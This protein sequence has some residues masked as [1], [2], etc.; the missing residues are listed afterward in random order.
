MG[1]R[2]M[3]VHSTGSFQDHR[4]LSL[5]QRKHQ[6]LKPHRHRVRCLTGR[7]PWA[8]SRL[9]R[10]VDQQVLEIEIHVWGASLRTAHL[11]KR[12]VAPTEL[13]DVFCKAVLGFLSVLLEVFLGPRHRRGRDCRR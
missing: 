3:Q 8:R 7:D 2:H 12:L 13:I 5:L 11:E 6:R 1:S 4:G 9:V 10:T